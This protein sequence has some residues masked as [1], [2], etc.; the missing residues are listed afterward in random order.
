[1]LH[2]CSPLHPT[3]IGPRDL[4]M[5]GA[6]LD[7]PVCQGCVARIGAD[8]S[9]TKTATAAHA[10]EANPAQAIDP[11]LRETICGFR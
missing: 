3:L 11:G 8:G 4:G 2:T 1:M 9:S 6:E 5:M 10:A 7:L